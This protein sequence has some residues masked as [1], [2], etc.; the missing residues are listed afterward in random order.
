METIKIP[1]RETETETEDIELHCSVPG[2]IWEERR[3]RT[4]GGYCK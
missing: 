1:S 3:V 2:L 4:R